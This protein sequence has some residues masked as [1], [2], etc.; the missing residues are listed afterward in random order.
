GF[1]FEH[2]RPAL[3]R[4]H[5]RRN[6]RLLDHSAFRR[7]VPVENGYPSLVMIRIF[8]RPDNLGPKNAR[9]SE[10]LPRRPSRNGKRGRIYQLAAR[11]LLHHSLYAPCRVE[12]FQEMRSTGS[13]AAKVRRT[14]A[15]L[16]ENA[17][18]EADSCLN[19]NCRDVKDSVRG[20][21]K[22]HVHS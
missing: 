8:E 2:T 13:Q 4:K 17:E 3:P 5:L 11:K 14:G 20:T 10:V 12:V 9:F 21:A 22:G 18:I 16:V 15:D 7:N 1:A 6:C 19:C